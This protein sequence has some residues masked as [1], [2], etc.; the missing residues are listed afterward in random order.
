MQEQLTALTERFRELPREVLVV[1]AVGLTFTTAL[2]LWWSKNGGFKRNP[3][4]GDFSKHPS[5]PSWPAFHTAPKVGDFLR[6]VS[7]SA[8]PENYRVLEDA[9]VCLRVKFLNNISRVS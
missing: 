8:V 5:P 3:P 7:R 2:A 6:N 4:S 9:C 1:G